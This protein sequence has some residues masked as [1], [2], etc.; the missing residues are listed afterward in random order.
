MKVA[1]YIRVSTADQNNELKR[2]ELNEY[3][4][5]HGCGIAGGAHRIENIRKPRLNV[6]PFQ[7]TGE[8][9]RVAE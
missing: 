8:V 4:E 7:V 5:R 6:V 9:S 3:A 1:I 2:R